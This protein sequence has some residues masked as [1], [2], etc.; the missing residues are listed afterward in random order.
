MRLSRRDPQWRHLGSRG[1]LPSLRLVYDEG[2][3]D[4]GEMRGFRRH[5]R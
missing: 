4:A 3:G 2:V 1:G 5:H